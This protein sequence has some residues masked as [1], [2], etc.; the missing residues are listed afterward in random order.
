MRLRSRSVLLRFGFVLAVVAVALLLMA[1]THTAKAGAP[2]KFQVRVWQNFEDADEVWVSARMVNGSWGTLGTFPLPLDYGSQGRYRYGDFRIE[3]PDRRD[4]PRYFDVR[5]WQSIEDAQDFDIS[6]RPEGGHWLTLTRLSVSLDDGISRNGRFRYGD[7]TATFP[8]SNLPWYRLDGP[9]PCPGVHA[10]G[11]GAAY[12]GEFERLSVTAIC[13]WVDDAGEVRHSRL[14]EI[15][16]GYRLWR[17]IEIT[18]Y[19]KNLTLS[20]FDPS[21]YVRDT[22]YLIDGVCTLSSWLA[23]GTGIAGPL[24]SFATMAACVRAGGEEGSP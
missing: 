19:E 23:P 11:W 9:S 24:R 14:W 22:V 20:F 12:F 6:A 18:G 16:L 17:D 7:V 1:G 3:V 8:L 4:P 5:I 2:L 21:Y 15:Y 13:I 10:P